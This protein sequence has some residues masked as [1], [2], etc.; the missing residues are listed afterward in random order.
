M[1]WGELP[2][3]LLVIA[4]I[5][6]SVRPDDNVDVRTPRQVPQP[7]IQAED[8]PT[9]PAPRSP[10]LGD[11]RYVVE[12]PGAKQN[13]VGTAFAIDDDGLWITARH[14]VGG[15][16]ALGF[17]RPGIRGTNEAGPAWIHPHSDMAVV[18]GPSARAG[19]ELAPRPAGQGANAFHI[20]FPRGRPGDV[21]S[22][23]IGSARMI[24][25]GRYRSNEPAV[26][27]AEVK[28]Y[29]DFTGGLGGISGGPIFNGTGQVIGVT[30]AENPRRGRII[31]TAPRTFATMFQ[32]A[33]RQPDAGKVTKPYIT[34]DN[35]QANGDRMRRRF[36]VA[37]LHCYVG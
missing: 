35:L 16:R 30:V 2:L 34:P 36:V 6:W 1:K 8:V 10:G 7:P 14:V 29:P 27:Y 22:K 26:A 32:I 19:F 37:R 33:D 25:R 15:C 23:V 13:S 20:G 5:Y 4:V 12:D 31:G 9:L 28:R 24:T 3:Y 21:W 18:E 11:P 17:A